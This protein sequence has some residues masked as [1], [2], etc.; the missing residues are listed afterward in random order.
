MAIVKDNAV[1]LSQGYGYANLEAQTP[2]CADTTLVRI[3]SITKLFTWTAVMQLVE[4]GR[5]DLHTDIQTYLDFDIPQ[6]YPEPIRVWHLL[7]HTAGFAD[8]GIRTGALEL[9]PG[10]TLRKT[11]IERHPPRIYPPGQIIAYSNYGAGLTGYIIERVSG[12]SWETYIETHLLEPLAM[13][14]TTPRE[15][16]PP[17]LEQDL[18]ASY[19]YR[20]GKY[21]PAPF[22]FNLTPPDG[23]ISATA[24]DMAQF[25]LAHL[26]NGAT[27]TARILHAD[28]ARQMHS[29]LFT[30]DPRLPGYAH[31]FV[32]TH[33]GR[34][35]LLYHTGGWE[36]FASLL[37]LIPEQQLGLFVAFNGNHGDQALSPLL[38]DFVAHLFPEPEPA[39]LP[40]IKLRVTAY[41]GY[42]RP[43]RAAVHT[44]E[45]LSWLKDA[46]RITATEQTLT[47]RNTRWQPITPECFR[48]IKRERYLC[49]QSI[50][51]SHIRL[52]SIGAYDYIRLAWYQSLP[53]NLALLT[54]CTLAFISGGVL[55]L[56]AGSYGVA[57]MPFAQGVLLAAL[58]SYLLTLATLGILLKFDV[59]TFT[60]KLP[61]TYTI[62]RHLIRSSLALTAIAL[63]CTVLIWLTQPWSIHWR[64]YYTLL[65]ITG[66][67]FSGW[68][69]YW[70]LL[71]TE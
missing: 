54:G 67:L 2:M 25:M 28:T 35:R 29:Q 62:L 64:S 60:Y 44:L 71:V 37:L 32:E 40:K 18:A 58:L 53:F 56:Q 59:E 33:R 41:T 23:S 50:P 34:Q 68:L 36:A 70:R 69:L 45:K 14:H 66:G 65:T 10:V 8:N 4:R 17:Q 48:D 3:A 7:S 5:L 1:I 42:Y 9:P 43:A 11:L 24:T 22:L 57:G 16:L 15:P 51:A 39:P 30:H 6:T 13:K 20:Q 61:F 19:T 12:M 47:F 38:V 46:I 31:G 26:Q 27:E 63:G 49:F 21:Q 55:W 52:A